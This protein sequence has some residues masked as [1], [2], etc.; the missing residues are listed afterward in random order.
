MAGQRQYGRGGF[1]AGG[2]GMSLF[3]RLT[4]TVKYLLIAN[5]AVFLVQLFIGRHMVSFFALIP[6]TVFPGAQI[7][8]IVTY[9]FMHGDFAHIFFNM[10]IL[11]F[12]GCPLEQIWG[13][14]KFLIYYFLCGVGAGIVC[15]PF[16]IIFGGAATP[17]VGASGA[18]FGLLAAFALIY[19]NALVFL[20][21]VFPIKA[22]WLVLIFIVM[23]F[24]ATASYA[25]GTTS[26]SVASIAH[27]A[28]AAVGYF[29]LRGLMDFKSYYLHWKQR[30]L[31]K[32]Y[33]VYDGKKDDDQRGP[34]LH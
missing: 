20:M 33:K 3:G 24:M 9:M 11:Y 14:D 6:E 22:K 13:R 28:G 29:Y 1:G 5:G 12:F 17:I 16:Y 4:P 7:W 26:S 32:A 15:I 31:K 2:G 8:R 21:G 34:W 18:L 30:K 10:L 19:P 25:G 27:L 23:E